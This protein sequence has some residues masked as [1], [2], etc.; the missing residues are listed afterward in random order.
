MMMRVTSE[1]MTMG[2]ASGGSD[3]TIDLADGGSSSTMD[4]VIS[5]HLG[6]DSLPDSSC[7]SR[8]ERSNSG[9]WAAT[10]CSNHL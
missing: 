8:K 9:R 4:T 3:T 10:W 2:L 1:G 5:P 7:S 6:E